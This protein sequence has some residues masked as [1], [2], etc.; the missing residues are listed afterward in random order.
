VKPTRYRLLRGILPTAVEGDLIRKNPC[1]I[2][3]AGVER[4]KERPVATIEQVYALA[5]AIEPR[6]RALVLTAHV[7][8]AYHR[9]PR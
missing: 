3:G 8:L 2:R 1:A 5:D 4:P 9:A 7:H 6:Y